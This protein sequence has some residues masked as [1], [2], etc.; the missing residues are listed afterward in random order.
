MVRRSAAQESPWW[1]QDSHEL[2]ML[3]RYEDFLFRLSTAGG[4]EKPRGRLEPW[5]RWRPQV[6]YWDG[7]PADFALRLGRWA[8]QRSWVAAFWWHMLHTCIA[9]RNGG[10]TWEPV[11]CPGR[12]G[13]LHVEREM[14]DLKHEV[15]GERYYRWPEWGMQ[16]AWHMLWLF[17][18]VHLRNPETCIKVL[19]YRI[20][21]TSVNSA[22]CCSLLA[23]ME[24]KGGE[25]T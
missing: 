14:S 10:H 23:V 12:A 25:S 13:V 3:E 11:T 9:G 24:V 5:N 4:V 15:Y 1:H 2:A 16:Y 21:E 17:E 8:G 6:T 7:R 20:L 22:C 18:E 19:D